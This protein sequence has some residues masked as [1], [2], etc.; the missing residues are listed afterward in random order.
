MNYMLLLSSLFLSTAL[1]VL[2]FKRKG[3]KSLGLFVAFVINVSFLGT[4]MWILYTL[5]EFRFVSFNHYLLFFA[6][7]IVTWINFIILEVV[8]YKELRIKS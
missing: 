5:S 3:N 4:A 2:T 6:I 1:S 7:P 8:R